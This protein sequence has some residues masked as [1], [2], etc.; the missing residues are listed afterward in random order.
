MKK[1][2]EILAKERE[3][4]GLSQSDLAR[5]MKVKPN[6]VNYWE[7]ADHVSTKTLEK[8]AKALNKEISIR[9]F[10]SDEL[11]ADRPDVATIY[12]TAIL[13]KKT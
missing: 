11:K 7:K 9:F 1:I 8:Y 4:S 5:L 6:M 3:K 10:N 2:G 13:T 12:N